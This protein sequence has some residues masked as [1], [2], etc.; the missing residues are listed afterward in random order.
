VA[1]ARIAEE[2]GVEVIVAAPHANDRLYGIYRIVDGIYLL[3]AKLES[4]YSGVKI[5]LSAEVS[6]KVDSKLSG[7]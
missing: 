1:E 3:K 6:T 2:D 7:S 4:K 5:I